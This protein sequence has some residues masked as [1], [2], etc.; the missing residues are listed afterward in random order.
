MY[1]ILLPFAH[2]TDVNSR[3]VHDTAASLTPERVAAF[4]QSLLD[5][6]KSW[7]MRSEEEQ[8]SIKSWDQIIR[9]IGP[10][11]FDP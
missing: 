5:W 1:A 2:F 10:L 6:L 4:R 3:N 7:S 9:M 11:R 8:Q